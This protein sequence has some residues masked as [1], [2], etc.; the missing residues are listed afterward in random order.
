LDWTLAPETWTALDPEW[1]DRVN[2]A[3]FQKQQREK[4]R[5]EKAAAKWARKEARA[6]AAAD[7][8]PD[9]GPPMLDEET[10]LTQLAELHQRFE[11]DA[12]TFEDFEAAK[13]ELMERLRVE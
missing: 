2:Q 6:S 1:S 4:A 3:R 13:A 7:E 12:I 10:V 5:R 8:T 9:D 11:A